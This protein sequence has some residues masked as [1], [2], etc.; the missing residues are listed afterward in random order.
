MEAAELLNQTDKKA[1]L[2]AE[3]LLQNTGKR[4]SVDTGV[5]QE[6]IQEMVRLQIQQ[7]LKKPMRDQP[8]THHVECH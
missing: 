4:V 7:R 8:I 3:A 6:G 5:T 1:A 2:I